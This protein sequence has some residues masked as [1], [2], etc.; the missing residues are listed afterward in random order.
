[1]VNLNKG[2]VDLFKYTKPVTAICKFVCKVNTI[3]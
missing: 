3:K 2:K 1:M